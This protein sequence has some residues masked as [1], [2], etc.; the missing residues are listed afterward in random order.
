MRDD[1]RDPI[2]AALLDGPFRRLRDDNHVDPHRILV[3]DQAAAAGDPGGDRSWSCWAATPAV[4]T[5]GTPSGAARTWWR[6]CGRSASCC[7]CS[8]VAQEIAGERGR[9]RAG[10]RHG[11]ADHQP[12]TLSYRTAGRWCRPASSPGSA[13]QP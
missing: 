2:L 10:V 9:G 4:R 1:E 7:V 3:W 6:S 12:Q 8:L 5:T 13:D 11:G